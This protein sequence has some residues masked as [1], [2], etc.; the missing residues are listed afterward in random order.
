MRGIQFEPHVYYRC[1][2]YDVTF[3]LAHP[4]GAVG[5]FR[6]RETR[7]IKGAAWVG[8]VF[9]GD[10][11]G[12]YML[13]MNIPNVTNNADCNG[14]RYRDP[15]GEFPWERPGGWPVFQA[16]SVASKTLSGSGLPSATW[17]FAYRNYSGGALDNNWTKITGPDGTSRTY[18]HQAIGDDHGLLKSMVVTSPSGAGETITYE[19]NQHGGGAPGGTYGYCHAEGAHPGEENVA[20]RCQLYLKRPVTRVNHLRDGDTYTTTYNYNF[21]PSSSS[22][23]SQ[24]VSMS[25]YSSI[26]G[27]TAPRTTTT[28]YEQNT[29]R[30]I[31]DLPKT[32]TRNGRQ[33]A[34]YVYNSL[35][36][37]TSQTRYGQ[38][39]ARFTYH[40]DGNLATI[41]DAIGRQVYATNYKRGVAQNVRRPDNRYVYVTVDNNGWVTSTRDAMGRVTSYSR[42]NMGRLT[43]INPAGSWANT[44]IAYN[45]SGGGAVQTITEGQ[46]RETITYDKMYRP[47]LERTQALDTGW[48]SYVRTQYN[49]AGQVTFK[50]QP[51]SNPG[52]TRGV[53]YSYD[54]LGRIFDERENVAPY[55]TTRHRYYSSARHRVIDPSG[56]FT[57]F[58]SYGYDGPG[59]TDYRAIYKYANGAW[60]QYTY[61]YKNVHGQMTRLRQWGHNHSYNDKSQYFYYDGQQRL[62]RHYVPE[63]GA[64]R[65]QYDAAG[66]MVAYAKGQSNSGCGSIAAT[67]ARVTQQ[68]DAL[69]QPTLT[70]FYSSGTPDISK[71]YDANGNVTAINRGGV[72]W[73]Y[74]YND[75]D[76]LTSER[77]DIDGRN[78]DMSYYYNSSGHLYRKILPSGRNIYITPDGLGRARTIVNNSSFLASNIGYHADGSLSAMNYG[79]GQ[80]LSRTLNARLLPHRLRSYRGS[81]IAIDQTFGYDARG[82]I[83]SIVDAAVGGNNRSYGYDGL[84]RLT[85]ATGPWGTGSFTYDSL[86]N[87]R[88]KR[89]GSR[90]VN[91]SYNGNN[92][93]TQSADTG[94]SGTRGLGY[95]ARGNVTSLGALGFV[96]DYA[97][98]P[99]SV[100]GT[101]SGNYRYDGNLKRVRAVVNGKT[102][103]NVYDAGGSLVHIDEVSDNKRTDY[104]GGPGGPLARITNHAVTFLHPNHLGSA[105]SGSNGAGTVI[106]RE[107]YTPFGEAMNGHAANANQAGYTGHIKDSATGLS[108]MQARYYDPVIGRFL[109]VDP[110]DFLQSGNDPRFFNRYAYV[111]NDPTNGIDPDGEWGIV[112]ALSSVAMG[113]VIRGVTGGDVFDA[114]AMATDAALGAVGAGIANKAVQLNRLRQTGLSAGQRLRATDDLAR[115]PTEGVYVLRE[116]GETYVGQ[117]GNL[118]QRSA[119]SAAERGLQNAPGVRIGVN[120]GKTSREVAEQRTLNAAGGRDGPGV[121]NSVNPVGP[122]RA[123][124]MQNPALGNVSSVY[125]QGV[126]QA[127]QAAVGATAGAANNCVD[128]EFSGGC[129]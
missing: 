104:V 6:L 71:A 47:I 37:K 28:T 97:D 66:Q 69:G 55:A 85:S 4:D 56:A 68:Y 117:S 111:Y 67:A 39:E 54:G 119:Q 121:L 32:I 46:S 26:S 59:N 98:Q 61:L 77:L 92:R 109:S 76:L 81:Q 18:T 44:V 17:N 110:V 50:S 21:N 115:A 13:P 5:T 10:T 118:A 91:L 19:H 14:T 33:L 126:N 129:N 34:T 40:G 58:Y 101:A 89:L 45:F 125:A 70:N 114:G 116:G 48:S 62:C 128:H 49:G 65:Y 93:L 27:S 15:N 1:V 95:D 103:Y 60:Q 123:A 83:T 8:D 2:P 86:D 51:S 42:D 63:H 57:Q 99:V 80:I 36:K 122:K 52:E 79:N 29:A 53:T 16:M 112:G 7:H 87:L 41:T 105:Q 30:W 90:T 96:Y 25:Q 3:D 73:S 100:S 11:P 102:I 74:S 106:W 43:L 82:K 20:G 94:S 9:L 35:G 108:Y 22:F 124:L 24:P 84:G 120:G 23:A 72:N 113:M 75:I 78:Y 12:H 31:R 88:Q 127:G 107:R 38:F 64:T